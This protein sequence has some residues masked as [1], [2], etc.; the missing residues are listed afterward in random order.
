MPQARWRRPSRAGAACSCSA[1]TLPHVLRTWHVPAYSTCTALH[2]CMPT[3]RLVGVAAGRLRRSALGGRATH[4]PVPTTSCPCLYTLHF[5][6]AAHPRHHAASSMPPACVM[7]P[8]P[9]A[10]AAAV[11]PRP[12]RAAVS[13]SADLFARALCA[14]CRHRP[15]R[16]RTAHACKIRPRCPPMHACMYAGYF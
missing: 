4:V 2:F 7:R 6:H 14:A 15:S 12:R 9:P 5:D 1:A 8:P 16:T 10:P 3:G 13:G 11:C